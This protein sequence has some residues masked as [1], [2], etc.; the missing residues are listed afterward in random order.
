[1][2]LTNPVFYT[3]IRLHKKEKSLD[4]DSRYQRK[5]TASRNGVSRRQIS[6]IENHFR[7]VWLNIS[8]LCR[9]P[10]LYG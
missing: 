9:Y 5:H 3:M 6:G 2:P 10:P 7:A 8:K 4:E 1:M